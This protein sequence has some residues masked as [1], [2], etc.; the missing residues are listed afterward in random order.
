M[1][2]KL[3]K[4]FLGSGLSAGIKEEKNRKDLGLLVCEND[5]ILGGVYTQNRFPSAHVQ[6]C[7]PLTP[8]S[9]FRALIVNSGNANAATGSLGL[10][11]NKLIV[12]QVAEQLDISPD[13]VFTSS[14]GIIGQQLPL[15]IIS[16]AVPP[17]I[18]D[19]KS[20]GQDFAEAIMTTDLKVKTASAEVVIDD[21]SYLIS[22]FAKGSG[23]IHPNMATMLAYI[24]TDAPLPTSEIQPITEKI[25]SESFNCISV[26]GDTSTN[27]TF[28]LISSNPVDDLTPDTISSVKE[29]I[30]EVAITLAKKIAADGEGAEHLLEVRIAE[31]PSKEIA[32]KLL[33]AILT[34]NLVKTA[35]HGKDPNWGDRKSVV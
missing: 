6:Y 17:L 14:T 32:K 24:V 18:S 7:K 28:L 11:N 1:D 3:P 21:Q 20:S 30:L 16:T 13:S 35:V 31:S 12:A 27:D 23:M 4:G 26:D 22:G 5:A 29:A 15:D 8:S 25:A 19:L 10:E 34:S 9:K 33:D 2:S